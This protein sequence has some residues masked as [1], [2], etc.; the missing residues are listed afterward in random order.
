MG[1]IV[2]QKEALVIRK[3]LRKESKTTVFT[4]GLFD[5]LHLGHIEYLQKAKDLGDVLIVGLNSDTSVRL[6]KGEKRPIMPQDER[7][8][9]LAA[10]ACV[11][12]VVVFEE[13]TAERLVGV[14][15]P[16]IYVKGGDYTMEREGELRMGKVPPEAQIV[17]AYGGEV[18]ILPYL[19][20]HSTTNIIETIL[21]RYKGM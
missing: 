1:E 16:D 9:L 6:L 18:H 20:G 19:A 3:R 12:Y 4:N 8:R 7:A 5:I 17:A 15:R 13:R 11:D 2:S 14:L 10:L 21:Q